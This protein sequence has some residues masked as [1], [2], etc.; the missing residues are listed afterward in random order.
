M[1]SRAR[2]ESLMLARRK[3]LGMHIEILASKSKCNKA[4]ISMTEGGY[5]PKLPTMIRIAAALE[6]TPELLW[7]DEFEAVDE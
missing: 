3:Q 2:D 1:M 5:I 6:T 7:P 4:L